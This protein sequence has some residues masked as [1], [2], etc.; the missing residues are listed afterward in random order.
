MPLSLLFPNKC[1]LCGEFLRAKETDLCHK[2]RTDAPKYTKSKRKIPLIAQWTAVWYYKG[3][4]RQ[5]IHRFKFGNARR[6]A[7]VY[8]RQ[9]AVAIIQAG[10]SDNFDFITWVPISFLRYLKRGYNQSALLAKALSTELGIPA[11]RLLKKVRHTPAQSGIQ[12]GAQRRA[13]IAN[14]YTITDAEQ[15]RG[16]KVLIVDDVLTTGATVSE[17]AK[18]LATGGVSKLY[19]AAIAT[20]EKNK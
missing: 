6:Y 2:C 13:N 16:Q 20:S 9:M 12:G 3:D 17:C 15:I 5:S 19:F 7:D 1:V 11:R 14:A 10:F 4:V 18:T 8:A